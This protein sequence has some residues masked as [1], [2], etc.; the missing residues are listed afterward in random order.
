M[1]ERLM[2]S[3]IRYG[4]PKYS[5]IDSEIRETKRALA[6]ELDEDGLN[7][8]E[9]LSD[10]YLRQ[11]SVQIEGAFIDG[12]CTAVDLIFDVILHSTE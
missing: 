10:A 8:L 4:E 2:K 9:N 12:F 1:I 3:E 5:K 7:L 6:K 11:T